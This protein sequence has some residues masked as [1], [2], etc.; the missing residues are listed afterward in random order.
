VHGPP[1]DIH[2]GKTITL[3][4]ADAAPAYR[5]A[6]E[7]IGGWR[8]DIDPPWDADALRRHVAT[9]QVLEAL[10]TLG[11]EVDVDLHDGWLCLSV[12]QVWAEDRQLDW[13]CHAA[14]RIADGIQAAVAAQPALDHGTPLNGPRETDQK[15]W[16]DEG[17]ARVSWPQPPASIAEAKAAYANAERGGSRKR[18]RKASVIAV[19]GAVVALVLFAM[20]DLVALAFGVPLIL[21]GAAIVL[22]ILFFLPWTVY[23]AWRAGSQMGSADLENRSGQ[24]G[25]AA[26]TSEYGR[27]RGLRE[28]DRDELRYR[29]EPPVPGVP[30]RAWHGPLGGTDGPRGRLVIWI[31]RT[32]IGTSNYALVAAVPDPGGDVPSTVGPYRVWRSAGTLMLVEQIAAEDRSA[33]KLDAIAAAARDVSLQSSDMLQTQPT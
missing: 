22:E 18:G 5:T 32:E 16:I 19:I 23:T 4:G 2:V 26:F 28:E 1:P 25:L 13:L 3:S 24:F 10:N 21:V 14:S 9:P 7:A 12:D 15:R 27:S 20:I 33:M 31:D 30:L 8:W 6:V 11:E 17:V 29:L